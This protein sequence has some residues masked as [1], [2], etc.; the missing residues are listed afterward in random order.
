MKD[1]GGG[2]K[3]GGMDRE[4]GEEALGRGDGEG[5]DFLQNCLKFS[6]N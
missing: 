4:V 5:D 1:R 3:R 6:K 2:R